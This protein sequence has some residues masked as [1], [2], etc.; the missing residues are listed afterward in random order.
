MLMARNR[1]DNEI[2]IIDMIKKQR[3]FEKAIQ[4]LLPLKKRLDLKERS[5]YIAIKPDMSD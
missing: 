5:R 2:N 1:L 4:I 3:Y